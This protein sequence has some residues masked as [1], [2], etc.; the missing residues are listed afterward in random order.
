MTYPAGY[1]PEG[2]AFGGRAFDGTQVAGDGR[3]R[4]Q[5]VSVAAA[6]DRTHGLAALVNGPGAS[7][8]WLLV[9]ALVDGPADSLALLYVGVPGAGTLADGSTAGD[10]DVAEWGTSGPYVPPSTPV[11]VVWTDGS[12]AALTSGAAQLRLEYTEVDA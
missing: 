3:V 4:R 11:Y 6:V 7:V 5:V 1:S 9:R 12:R 8:G 2:G 10:L